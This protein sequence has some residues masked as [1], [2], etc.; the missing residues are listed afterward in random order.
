MARGASY[1]HRVEP[2]S[3]P[4][5]PETHS[6]GGQGDAFGVLGAP[7]AALPPRPLADQ[8]AICSF[9]DSALFWPVGAAVDA[10]G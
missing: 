5:P 10:G 9:S 1:R 4:P 3:L 8:A 6:V 7:M 2:Q